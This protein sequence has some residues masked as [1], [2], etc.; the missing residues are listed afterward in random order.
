[1]LRRDKRADEGARRNYITDVKNDKDLIEDNEIEIQHQ[2]DPLF[3]KTT[4]HFDAQNAKGL[5]CNQQEINNQMLPILSTEVHTATAEEIERDTENNIKLSKTTYNVDWINEDDL[6]KMVDNVETAA[7]WQGYSNY[8]KF[9]GKDPKMLDRL[10]NINDEE[11]QLIFKEKE[12]TD[13][14]LNNEDNDN[15]GINLPDNNINTEND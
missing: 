9:F 15:K 3:T 6:K 8:E 4:S 12:V 11:I 7:L 10:I 13:I 1:M 5:L 2:R 14:L